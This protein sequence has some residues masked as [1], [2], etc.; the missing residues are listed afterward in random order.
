MAVCTC[1]Y[2][3]LVLSNIY[4]Q[5]PH[6][7]QQATIYRFWFDFITNQQE[8]VYL[9]NGPVFY[10][11]IRGAHVICNNKNFQK[12]HHT[13]GSITWFSLQKPPT[14]TMNQQK[15]WKKTLLSSLQ[16]IVV[17]PRL[18]LHVTALHPIPSTWVVGEVVVAFQPWHR[19]L[20]SRRLSWFGGKG[21]GDTWRERMS[22]YFKQ[23]QW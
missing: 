9:E 20:L 23:F 11:S 8:K 1:W 5:T 22:I 3:V 21:T 14:K 4:Y 19:V 13:F 15:T 2:S 10:C 17:L 6:H 18:E 12:K 7:Q 16:K